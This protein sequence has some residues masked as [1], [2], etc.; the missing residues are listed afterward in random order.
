MKLNFNKSNIKEK[1]NI[2]LFLKNI[3]TTNS[4]LQ[5]EGQ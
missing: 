3:I 5:G 2:D 1:K 4:I